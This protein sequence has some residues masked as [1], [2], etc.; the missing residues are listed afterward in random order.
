MRRLCIYSNLDYAGFGTC[1]T[2]KLMFGAIVATSQIEFDCVT[3]LLESIP[4]ALI[5]LVWLLTTGLKKGAGPEG[6][7]S[8]DR[9]IT[10]PT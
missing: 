10:G 1:N 2:P 6:G 4:L 9:S 3:L 5:S 7:L 8:S